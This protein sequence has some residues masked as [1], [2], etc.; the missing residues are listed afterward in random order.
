M[1]LVTAAT[2]GVVLLASGASTAAE[3]S[4]GA[5]DSGK[6]GP[7]PGGA[8]S[9]PGAAIAGP[10]GIETGIEPLSLDETRALTTAYKPWEVGTSFTIHRLIVQ[11]DTSGGSPTPSAQPNGGSGGAKQCN[12]YEVYVRYDLT[13]NDRVGVSAY[14]F[15]YFVAD[16]GEY[17]VRFDDM[18]FTYTHIFKLPK[19]YRIQTGLLVTAPTSFASQL[20]GLITAIQPKVD[21][22]KRFGAI[23]VNVHLADTVFIQRYESFAG[24]G[25]GDPTSLDTL[26]IGV[27]AELHMPFHEPLS[28][29]IDIV[30]GYSWANNIQSGVGPGHSS[31]NSTKDAAGGGV[32]DAEFPTQPIQ[33]TYGWDAFMSY[34]IPDL[35]G[36]RSN[37]T[38]SYNFGDGA[39]GYTSLLQDGIGHVFLGY[40]HNSVLELSMGLRY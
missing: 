27:G 1:R 10:T 26:A 31:G 33:Q 21:L 24:S 28:V 36:F 18:A 15:E 19:K 40:R 8:S 35:F 37:L 25:G 29:G 16:Q 7:G 34:A 14:A 6:G 12:T 13:K 39:V 2:L 11:G 23:S 4:K 30:D 22:D 20:E 32:S 3:G 17:G 5:D 38:F 9:S